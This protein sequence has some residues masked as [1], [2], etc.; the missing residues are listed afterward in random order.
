MASNKKRATPWER[1]TPKKVQKRGTKH[2]TSAQKKHA[3]QRA[4]RAGRPYPNMVDNMHEAQQSGA[5][6]TKK[7]A[8]KKKAAK[9]TTRRPAAKR[10][11]TKR[12]AKRTSTRKKATRRTKPRE[13]DPRGGLTAA[14]RRAFHDRDGSNLKPGVK[15][16]TSE[17]SLQDMKRKGSWAVRFYGRKKLP[18]LVDE[19]GRPTRFALSAAAWGEPVPKTEAAARKIADKG[20]R[21]LERARS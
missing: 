18:A 3:A 4:Q 1:P 13:K 6:P 15:K 12:A 9:K 7:K 2:L 10:T 19:Q 5:K 11:T 20:H 16:K 17:M 8:S 14:G 21:L